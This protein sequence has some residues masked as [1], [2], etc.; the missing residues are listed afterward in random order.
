MGPA[1]TRGSSVFL[2]DMEGTRSMRAVNMSLDGPLDGS[3][4]GMRIRL[5]VI[6]CF[7]IVWR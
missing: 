6:H 7:P 3:V 1:V 5:S 2:H 4:K